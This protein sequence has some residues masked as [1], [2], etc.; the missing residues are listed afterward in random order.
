MATKQLFWIDPWAASDATKQAEVIFSTDKNLRELPNKVEN[1]SQTSFQRG[2]TH[3]LPGNHK[4]DEHRFIL[5]T[6][7]TTTI[8]PVHDV[9]RDATP[10]LLSVR[11]RNKKD[12]APVAIRSVTARSLVFNFPRRF[13]RL[14]GPPSTKN[15]TNFSGRRQLTPPSTSRAPPVHR[16]CRVRARRTSQRFIRR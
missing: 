4:I 14:R 8:T 2:N 10:R 12:R 9:R 13:S 15:Q 11:T 16:T 3:G 7:S 5:I 1:M 6:Y